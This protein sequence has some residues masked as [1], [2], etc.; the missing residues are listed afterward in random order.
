M[1]NILHVNV[2]YYLLRRIHRLKGSDA[3]W[4]H[5][6]EPP[7][8]HLDYSDDEE[9]RAARKKLQEKRRTEAEGERQE[10]TLARSGE[11]TEKKSENLFMPSSFISLCGCVHSHVVYMHMSP[12]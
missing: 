10:E 1:Y 2:L 7:E 5:D 9:E 6:I 3:S 12:D 8:D 4:E 11:R